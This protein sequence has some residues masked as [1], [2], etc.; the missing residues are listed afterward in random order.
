MNNTDKIP[1]N[2]LENDKVQIPP[3]G[4]P[5]TSKFGDFP[6]GE[7]QNAIVTIYGTDPIT[8]YSIQN[9]IAS[10][11]LAKKSKWPDAEAKH[12]KGDKLGIDTKK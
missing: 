11:Q 12:E 9:L 8:W 2:Q 1:L 4:Q 5:N 7:N 10:L 3:M 6:I